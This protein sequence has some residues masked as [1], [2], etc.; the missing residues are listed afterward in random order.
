MGG[1][2][3]HLPDF[4]LRRATDEGSCK[5]FQTDIIDLLTSDLQHDVVD[6][7]VAQVL[8]PCDCAAGSGQLGHGHL[9][10][11][12]VDQVTVARDGTLNFLTEVTG[13]VERLFN[14]FE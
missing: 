8:C 14:G 11:H 7:G 1:A 9:E 2:A 6:Q 10:V 12:A 3:R 4:L 13:T 5:L